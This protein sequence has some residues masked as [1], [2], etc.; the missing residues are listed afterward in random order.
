MFALKIDVLIVKI[1]N[2]I[3]T[4]HEISK[5]IQQLYNEICLDRILWRPTNFVTESF[6][7][8]LNIFTAK[9]KYTNDYI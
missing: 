3:F 5:K 1:Y 6:L 4:V 7:E 9:G 2:K 8:F